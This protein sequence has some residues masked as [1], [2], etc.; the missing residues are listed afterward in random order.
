MRLVQKTNCCNYFESKKVSFNI[1]KNNS[2]YKVFFYYTGVLKFSKL[3]YT[4]Y[5][6]T[7]YIR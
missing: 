4:E 6:I 2:Q 5:K 7:F 1:T 3:L